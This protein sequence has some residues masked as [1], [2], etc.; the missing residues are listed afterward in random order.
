MSSVVLVTMVLGSSGM[1]PV[2]ILA[3]MVSFVVSELLPTGRTARSA[4][5]AAAGAA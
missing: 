5:V 3:A 2:V 1:M 4:D